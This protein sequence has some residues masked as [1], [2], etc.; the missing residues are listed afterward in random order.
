MKKRSIKKTRASWSSLRSKLRQGRSLA[1]YQAW[2]SQGWKRKKMLKLLT[3]AVKLTN[4][5]WNLRVQLCIINHHLA[6]LHSLKGHQS[7]HWTIWLVLQLLIHQQNL[8]ERN[9]RPPSG[10]K[11]KIH[12]LRN[13]FHWILILTQALE[14]ETR[15]S[16]SYRSITTCWLKEFRITLLQK[17]PSTLAVPSNKWALMGMVS[18]LHIQTTTSNFP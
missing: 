12:N 7:I 4:S 16:F 14:G 15:V 9:P 18:L 10:S 11:W 3:M 2:K 8:K 13:F 5:R 6:L 17:A 1:S